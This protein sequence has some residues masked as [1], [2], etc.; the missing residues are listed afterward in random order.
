MSLRTPETQTVL[1]HVLS[2]EREEIYGVHLVPLLMTL[3]VFLVDL[4]DSESL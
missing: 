3:N 4:A 2:G 1:S